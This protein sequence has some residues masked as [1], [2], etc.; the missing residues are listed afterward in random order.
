MIFTYYWGF[1]CVGINKE[2]GKQ[3]GAFIG[4]QKYETNVRMGQCDISA[5]SGI[6]A[7]CDL[8]GLR[9]GYSPAEIVYS[10]KPDE[11]V[12]LDREQ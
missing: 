11:M 9:H 6:R 3:C 1:I 4:A 10:L 8:C 7:D 2:T 12:P 5:E